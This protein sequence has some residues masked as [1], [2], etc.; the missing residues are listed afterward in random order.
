MLTVI[1]GA[2]FIVLQVLSYIG[3]MAAGGVQ[4]F[5]TFSINELFY[6]L[7]YNWLGIVG[8]ILLIL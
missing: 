8:A 6:F 5:A 3:N 4:F 2:I 7:G 1:V